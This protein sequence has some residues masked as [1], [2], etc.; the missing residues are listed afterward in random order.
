MKR[1]VT[2]I[3]PCDWVI[4]RGKARVVIS[5][6]PVGQWKRHLVLTDDA[7]GYFDVIVYNAESL[8]M[9]P[10]PNEITDFRFIISGRLV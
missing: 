2:E 6:N 5:N 9:A 10:D 3:N 4:Y 8:T 7:L 1:K